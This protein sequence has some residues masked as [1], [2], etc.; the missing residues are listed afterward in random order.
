[1]VVGSS[2]PGGSGDPDADSTGDGEEPG[3]HPAFEG[4]DVDAPGSP[5]SASAG[6][7][8]VA[9]DQGPVGQLPATRARAVRPGL[10]ADD[11]YTMLKMLG[12]AIRPM[13]GHQLEEAA[14][15]CYLELLLS[16]PAC[17]ARSASGHRHRSVRDSPLH[18]SQE[19][20]LVTTG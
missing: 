9:Q 15:T 19:P 8:A 5:V 13:A 20:P 18:G 11:V 6:P 3:G 1:M 10:A 17:R 16:G 4:A 7:P 12:A 2:G 14:W